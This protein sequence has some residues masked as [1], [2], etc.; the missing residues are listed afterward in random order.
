M[1]MSKILLALI[2][3][4]LFYLIYLR[5]FIY[6][7]EYVKHLESFLYGVALALLLKLGTPFIYS[8]FPFTDLALDG[9]LKAALIE[10]IGAFCLIYLVHRYYPNFSI[11]ESVV[12]AMMLGIGFSLVE[13]VFYA[14]NFGSSI[15]ILRLIVSVPVHLTTCGFIGY[16]LGLRR[17]SETPVYRK[18]YIAKA[19]LIPIL[20][21]GIFDTSLIVGGKMIYFVCPFLIIFVLILEVMIARI[22][23]IFPMDVLDAMNLR[24]E[25]WLTID[26]QP[27]FERWILNS[28]GTQ[29]T[30]S[31]PFFRWKREAFTWVMMFFFITV[32]VVMLLFQ[33]S[34]MQFLSLSLKQDEQFIIMGLFPTSIG[35]ILLLVGAINPQFFEESVIRI[36]VISDVVLYNDTNHHMEETFVTFDITAANCFLRTSEPLG[37]G[38]EF[39][40]LFECASFVSPEARGTVVWENFTNDQAPKGSLIRLTCLPKGFITFLARYYIFR[41]TKGIA[42]NLKMPGFEVIR[43]FFMRPITTMQ[44]EKSLKS[45]TI[46]YKEEEK[47]NKFYLIKKGRVLFYKKKKSGDIIVMDT[48]EVGEIFGEMSVL[49]NYPRSE[50]AVCGTDCLLAVAERDNLDALIRNNPDFALSLIKKLADRVNMSEKVLSENIFTLER[51]RRE[52]QQLFHVAMLFILTGLGYNPEGDNI[53]LKLDLAKIAGIIRN[54]D[55]EV[56]SEIIN[57]VM[58]KQSS[59]FDGMNDIS[60]EIFQELE[61]ISSRFDVDI[62]F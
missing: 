44:N 6:K 28:M 51:Q 20:L 53:N 48:A 23:T 62:N 15:I 47:G 27:H 59:L 38:T 56:A 7:P 18:Q 8:L 19:L 26:R 41:F 11:M 61:I 31:I 35:L 40:L 58:R 32:A 9:F 45:N 46:I 1:L 34:I 17:L 37:L 13:N 3:I 52:S 29:N 21:H 16:Y 42:F 24:F 22:H 36:P 55:D 5:Y 57:L 10:K 54:I 43:K 30:I 50:T 60:D 4:P 2:P 14:I 25:D 49:G 39:N 33:D 12:S